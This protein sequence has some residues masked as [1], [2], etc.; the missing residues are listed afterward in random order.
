MSDFAFPEIRILIVDVNTLGQ[1]WTRKSF[2]S[3]HWRLYWNAAQG[4]FVAH[5]GRRYELRP[6][7]FFL[8]PPNLDFSAYSPEPGPT[9]FYAHFIL[10]PQGDKVPRAIH[11]VPAAAADVASVKDLIGDIA[12]PNPQRFQTGLRGLS[13]VARVLAE[14]PEAWSGD[15][16]VLDERIAA[17]LRMLEYSPEVSN[18][19]L[20]KTVGM[21]RNAFIRAFKRETGVAPHAYGCGRRMDKARIMLSMSELAIDEIAEHLG[22]CDR[23]HFSKVFKR[24]SGASPVEFRIQQRARLKTALCPEP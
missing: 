13:L 15:E 19:H 2:C 10:A 11:A 21:S 4:A 1:W 14:C 6:D 3:P 8:I 20:A 18:D 5:G 7:H 12:S 16:M 23:F 17:A 9:Q 24:A 22:F